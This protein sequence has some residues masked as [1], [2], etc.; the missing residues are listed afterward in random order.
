MVY[1]EADMQILCYFN[2]YLLSKANLRVGRGQW[3]LTARD[4]S[5]LCAAFLSFA[6]SPI[7]AFTS[8]SVPSRLVSMGGF[9]WATLS[10]P[11]VP[12]VQRDEGTLGGLKSHA[13]WQELWSAGH[14][15]HRFSD[16]DMGHLMP[17]WCTPKLTSCTL[18]IPW[19]RLLALQMCPGQ[20]LNAL[21]SVGAPSTFLL[22]TSAFH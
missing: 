2:G 19:S 22:H 20:S 14:R 5:S 17:H 1:Q 11:S 13:E 18:S 10:L 3:K 4:S 15:Q 6:G 9:C 12:T 16:E 8:L 21:L 7:N